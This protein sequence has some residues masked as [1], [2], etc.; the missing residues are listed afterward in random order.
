MARTGL[1]MK[2]QP[3][4]TLRNLAPIDWIEAEIQLRVQRLGTYC[5]DIAA[6][7]VLVEIPH[8]HHKRGNRFHIRIDLSVAGEE[9]VVS[10]AP[11]LHTRKRDLE[12][13][14]PEKRVEIEAVRKDGRL[15]IREAFDI[16]KRQL[17]DYAQRR[18]HEVNAQVTA[19]RSRRPRTWSVDG[20]NG[21][22]SEEALWR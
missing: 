21:L 7:R 19:P 20:R 14:A 12:E 1:F 17:Q 22:R 13:A 3:I 11:D 10:H 4:V 15:V 6:C 18:R 2:L 5:A 9:I 16:A 8:R